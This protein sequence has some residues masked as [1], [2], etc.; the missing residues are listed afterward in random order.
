MKRIIVLLSF[1]LL[2]HNYAQNDTISIFYDIGKYKLNRNNQLKINNQLA[3]LNN[4]TKY[5]V[6]I[7]S[8][9][10]YLGSNKNNLELSSK[11]A[12]AV[13]NLLLKNKNLIISSIKYKG[14]GELPSKNNNSVGIKKHRKTCIIIKTESQ[15]VIDN[16]A[17]SKKG[18]VFILKH[19]VFD[20]GRHF[21]KKESISILKQLLTMLN[22][23]PKVIIEISGHVCCGKSLKD[24]LDGLDNDT[25]TYNL[26]ENRA[27]HIY[28]YLIRKNIDSSRLVYKGYGFLHPLIYPELTKEDKSNNR[29]VEIKVLKNK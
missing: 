21:I 12:E 28:N 18:D 13:Q 27:K 3:T 8:S 11:R 1:F 26:S 14:I 16:I 25:R 22:N 20:P 19:I 2:L 23:N 5:H 17:T 15:F 9:C 24:S 6:Q 10:D 4:N 29:R 7:I